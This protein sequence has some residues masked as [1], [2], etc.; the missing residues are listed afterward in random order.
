MAYM[1]RMQYVDELAALGG[2]LLFTCKK[3]SH[4]SYIPAANIT[5]RRGGSRLRELKFRCSR[6][7][8]RSPTIKT[9]VPWIEYANLLKD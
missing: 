4:K 3:C 1:K 8:D 9:F 5:N 6:C 2:V 7:R